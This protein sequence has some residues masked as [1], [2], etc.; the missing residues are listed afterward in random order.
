MALY[1]QRKKKKNKK[2]KNHIKNRLK[3][4]NICRLKEALQLNMPCFNDN[5]NNNTHTLSAQ[6]KPLGY[7]FLNAKLLLNAPI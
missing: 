2:I 5:N 4:V 7:L 3:I 6:G 1:F